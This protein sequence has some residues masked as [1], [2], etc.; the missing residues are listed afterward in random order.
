MH[1]IGYRYIVRSVDS[2][3]GFWYVWD[4]TT[5]DLVAEYRSA[6]S[7]HFACR[8]LNSYSRIIHA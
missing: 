5:N 2:D 1:D 6:K 4:L 7:A 3:F 8:A